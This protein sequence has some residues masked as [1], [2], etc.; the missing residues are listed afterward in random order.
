MPGNCIKIELFLVPFVSLDFFL[1]HPA[2]FGPVTADGK[3]TGA[4]IDTK[5]QRS[6]I[7]IAMYTNAYNK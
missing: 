2:S 1:L 4:K 7:C 6:K 5:Q 3:L